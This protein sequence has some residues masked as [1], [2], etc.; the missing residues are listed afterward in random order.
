MSVATMSR[1]TTRAYSRPYLKN[2]RKKNSGCGGINHVTMKKISN[3]NASQLYQSSFNKIHI[4][5]LLIMTIVFIKMS[6]DLFCGMKQLQEMINLSFYTA[7]CSLVWKSVKIQTG[8]TVSFL[9]RIR[10]LSV[11]SFFFP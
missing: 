5:S 8:E 2:L 7:L 6:K 3:M 10:S 4:S 9:F 1:K 11:N